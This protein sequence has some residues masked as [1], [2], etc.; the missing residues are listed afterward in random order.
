MYTHFGW[1]LTHTV[2]NESVQSLKEMLF[3]SNI[4]SAVAKWV[5]Y[6]V[7]ILSILLYGCE[8]WSLTKRLGLGYVRVFHNQCVRPMRRVAQ[9]HTW[10]HKISYESLRQRMHIYPIEF[11]AYRQQL[12][13]PVKVAR[14]NMSRLQRQ[15]LSLW[16]R[17]KS[18]IG[19][20]KHTYGATIK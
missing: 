19:R 13:W 6:V 15:M 17:N 4:I 8:W 18:P 3:S 12:L 10:K 5:V 2:S 11:H 9:K 16:V 14:I 7:V 20:P 1:Q